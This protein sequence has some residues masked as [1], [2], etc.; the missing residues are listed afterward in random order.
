MKNKSL[1]SALAILSLG[2]AA[3][4]CHA[5]LIAYWPLDDEDGV[6]AKDV[7]GGYDGA[8][9]GATWLTPGQVGTSA[10]T[11]VGGD[12]VVCD[13]GAISTTQD[14]TL[15][16]WMLDNQPSYGTVM[17]KSFADSTSGFD[18]L[19]RPT[20]EDS[21][22][23]FRIGGWQAYGGW[24]RECRLPL[25]A[26]NDGEWVHIACTYDSATDTASIY[27][28]GELPENGDFNPKTGIAGEGGYCDGI[29]N[30]T[31]NLDLLGTHETFN[32]V[33]DDV[34]MWDRALTPEEV[35]TVYASGPLAVERPPT[36]LAI[37]SLEL[38]S[39]E[40]QISLTWNS[41]E[42]DNYVVKYS[43]DLLNWDSDLDDSYPADAG[44]TTT[45]VF[46]ISEVDQS[47]PVFFRVER[48]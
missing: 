29:N 1:K 39:A 42:G 18:I 19:V 26:Y 16:W 11:S 41:V 48:Q 35:A 33:L 4:V 32:G 46:D 30:P 21:P 31:A 47:G 34:A 15:T 6:V 17:T 25:G 36:P 40:N 27:V 44:E 28:N 8:I 20:S 5:N 3:P 24:G 45:G 14:L 22:M 37:T 9:T 13:P 38:L 43:T 7:V 23:I 12:S 2:F 10:L